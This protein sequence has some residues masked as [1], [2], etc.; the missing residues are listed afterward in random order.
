MPSWRDLREKEEVEV[1][2]G[3][4][5]KGFIYNF[6]CVESNEFFFCLKLVGE[7]LE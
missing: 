4:L 5:E 1:A 3:S 6:L 7:A 2:V